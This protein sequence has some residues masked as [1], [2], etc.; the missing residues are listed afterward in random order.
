MWPRQQ[1][2]G[3]A[4][5][6][7]PISPLV[8]LSLWQPSEIKAVEIPNLHKF[9]QGNCGT[10]VEHQSVILKVVGSNPGTIYF[11]ESELCVL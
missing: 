4:V 6:C 2:S 5:H 10:L 7:E 9:E 11:E 8:L 1:P 3:K